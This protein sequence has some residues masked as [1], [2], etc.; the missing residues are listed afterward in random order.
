MRLTSRLPGQ[1][2][3][4]FGFVA[5]C[6]T[7]AGT[8]RAGLISEDLVAASAASVDA[9]AISLNPGESTAP[10]DEDST[11]AAGGSGL[12][13]TGHSNQQMLDAS[14]EVSSLI[15]VD[16]NGPN[17]KRRRGSNGTPGLGSGRGSGGLSGSNGQATTGPSNSSAPSNSS[18]GNPSGSGDSA[19][20]NSASEVGGPTA[21]GTDASNP[22]LPSSI[23]N[24]SYQF[25]ANVGAG[26]DGNSLPLY[27]DPP[28]A[29]GFTFTTNPGSPNFASVDVITPLPN[30]SI[31]EISFGGQTDQF[32][33]GSTFTFPGGGVS[34]FEISGINPADV[35]TGVD[36]VTKLTFTGSGDVSFT[37][38]PNP[39]PA[40]VTLLALGAA[41]LIGVRARRTRRSSS[42]G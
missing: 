6:I 7:L 26:S 2:L 37:Q 35:A 29:P 41:G 31:L 32:A 42:E 1:L 10:A 8:A 20:T 4:V 5:S 40:S 36:F 38:T 24:G 19:L 16:V 30:T 3:A 33:P 21:A 12:P 15:G 23:S 11:P 18:T 22:L 9:M 27:A 17:F 14:N 34:T 13:L 28:V 25:N 39:E